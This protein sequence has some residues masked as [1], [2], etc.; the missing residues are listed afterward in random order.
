MQIIKL[1]LYFIC[2]FNP[3]ISNEVAYIR[4]FEDDLNFKSNISMLSTERRGLKHMAVGYDENNQPV[5][6]EYYTAR[7]VL[8]KRVMLKYD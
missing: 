6:I 2:L 1:T 7:G 3:L 4:Y 5:K 8:D